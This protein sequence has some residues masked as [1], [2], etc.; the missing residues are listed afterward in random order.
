MLLLKESYTVS[1]KKTVENRSEVK[2]KR[3]KPKKPEGLFRVDVYKNDTVSFPFIR[4]IQKYK[5]IVFSNS[6][7]KD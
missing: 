6:R 1:E 5:Y 3:V 4:T 7:E 2:L